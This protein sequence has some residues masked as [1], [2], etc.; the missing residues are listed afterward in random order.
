[1]KNL[2]SYGILTFCILLFLGIGAIFSLSSSDVAK[3][4]PNYWEFTGDTLDESESIVFTVPQFVKN[5]TGYVFQVYSYEISGNLDANAIIWESCWETANRWFPVDTVA[6]TGTG[7]VYLE[8]V[9]RARRIK[10]E[11][12]T[13]TTAQS[14]IHHAAVQLTEEF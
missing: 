12:Q 1:M 3:A 10:L 13:D 14:G 8:G 9:T 2:K 7:N 5:K 11:V 4:R 6:I